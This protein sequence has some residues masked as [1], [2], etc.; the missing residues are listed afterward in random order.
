[1]NQRV[2]GIII[3]DEK[4]VLIERVKGDRTYYIFPGG[5]VEEGE[6]ILQALHRE[7][8]EKFL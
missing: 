7:M 1:M 8:T 5:G 6:T 3:K 4:I 2:R